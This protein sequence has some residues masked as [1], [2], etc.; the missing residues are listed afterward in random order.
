LPH[1]FG[2]LAAT[3]GL[4][5]GYVYTGKDLKQEWYQKG[6]KNARARS[7]ARHLDVCLPLN[8][9]LTLIG[10]M[11]DNWKSCCREKL[12]SEQ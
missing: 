3:S 4:Q 1:F 7:Q 8:T 9:S 12:Q 5:H 11:V 6:M 2:P 10:Q